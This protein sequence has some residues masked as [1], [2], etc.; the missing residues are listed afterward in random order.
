MREERN[1]IV[2]IDRQ[3]FLFLL[4]FFYCDFRGG[5]RE[6]FFAGIRERTTAEKSRK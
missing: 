2:L 4:I 1:C 3:V 5:Y 6:G